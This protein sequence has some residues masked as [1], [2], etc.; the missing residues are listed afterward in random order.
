MSSST[1][2]LSVISSKRALPSFDVTSM[3]N[4]NNLKMMMERAE[5]TLNHKLATQVDAYVSQSGLI[6]LSISA[7]QTAGIRQA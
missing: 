3:D 5:L 6:Y 2:N 7:M 4:I 1:N